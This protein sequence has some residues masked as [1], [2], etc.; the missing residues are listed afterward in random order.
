MPH[1]KAWLHCC[2]S[3]EPAISADFDDLDDLLAL[4]EDLLFGDEEGGPL[5]PGLAEQD[6]L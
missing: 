1:T 5:D 3:A 4:E 2:L 6:S